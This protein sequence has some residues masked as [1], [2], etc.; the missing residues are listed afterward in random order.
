MIPVGVGALELS[1]HPGSVD[2]LVHHEV[3]AL[4]GD[5]Y[6]LKNRDLGRVR[7]RHADQL[8]TVFAVVMTQ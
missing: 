7:L 3:I 4:K 2:G 1:V 5:S 6:R 8:V